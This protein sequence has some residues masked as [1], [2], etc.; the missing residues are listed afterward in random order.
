MG[1]EDKIPNCVK[2]LMMDSQQRAE[3]KI[4]DERAKEEK[5]RQEDA[6]II[7]ESRMLAQQKRQ[8]QG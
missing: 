5:E 1:I 2:R 7:Q 6:R 4:R 8:Q 3:Q